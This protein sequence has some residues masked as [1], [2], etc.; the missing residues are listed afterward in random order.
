MRRVLTVAAL[1]AAGAGSMPTAALA[2]PS[3]DGS[4]QFSGT[5]D[6]SPGLTNTPQAVTDVAHATGTCSGT[7]DRGGRQVA[8][9]NAP[10][11]YVASDHGD[12]VTCGEEI[13][14]GSGYLQFAPGNRINFKLYEKRA[15][16]A[17]T[18]IVKGTDAGQGA[19]EAH[20]SRDTDPVAALTACGANGLERAPVD[21]HLTTSS[22]ISGARAPSQRL[23]AT[24]R[25]TSSTPNTP[26]GGILNLVRPDGPDGKPKPEAVGVFE[27][28]EG[29]TINE[30]AVPVCTADDT[31]LQLEGE[32]ACPS[33]SHVGEG[34]ATLLTGFGPPLD[35]VTLDD[36]WYH[37]PGE[38]VALFTPHGTTA[39]V[40]KVI[41]VQIKGASFVAPL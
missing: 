3:F 23:Q 16:A 34:L 28:P 7:L 2:A 40:L 20:L 19:G 36:H 5:V 24:L 39:P 18:L 41:H 37:A 4:C 25:L 1:C 22:P 6:F 27:L 13:A 15:A 30:S 12:N 11:Q 10:V 32:A 21:I 33:A 35:P 31:T 14:V 9:S 17:A 26:S 29:T 8:V 38:I